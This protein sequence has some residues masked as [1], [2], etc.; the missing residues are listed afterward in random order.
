MIIYKTHISRIKM[1]KIKNLSYKVINFGIK[2][3]FSR[4]YSK[5]HE[6]MTVE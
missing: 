3:Q 5:D 6:W 4:Y 1:L 2:N